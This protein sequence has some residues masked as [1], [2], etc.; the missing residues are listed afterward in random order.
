LASYSDRRR[1]HRKT[2]LALAL[3]RELRPHFADGVW[4]AEF[5]ALADPGLV[6]ATVAAAVGLEQGGGEASAQRVARVLADWRLLLILDTCEHVIAAATAM[7]EAILGAGS[8]VHIIA[9]SRELLR[10]LRVRVKRR[11]VAGSALVRNRIDCRPLGV[12]PSLLVPSSRRPKLGV[13]N[14]MLEWRPTTPEDYPQ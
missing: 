2:T 12:E 8:A 6:P 9:I 3:A 1:Q 14:A 13:S 4:L 10:E 5:S 11:L 7:A